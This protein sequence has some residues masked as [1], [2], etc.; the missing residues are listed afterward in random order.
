MSEEVVLVNRKGQVTIPAS[1]R[2]KYG[3][4]EGMRVLVKESAE[5]ILITPITPIEELAG[6]AR[7]KVNRADAAAPPG[8]VNQRVIIEP[9]GGIGMGQYALLVAAVQAADPKGCVG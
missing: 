3:V 1:K 5:G 9:A 7:E 4:K 8:L 2:K 6:L